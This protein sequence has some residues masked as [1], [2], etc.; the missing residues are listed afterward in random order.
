MEW[1]KKIYSDTKF[2]V[3][4]GGDE[5]TDFVKQREGVWQG[6]TVTLFV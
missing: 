3:K 6:S 4:C 2:C 1:I 5:V